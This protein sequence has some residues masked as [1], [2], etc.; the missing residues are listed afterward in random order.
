[1]TVLITSIKQIILIN[2]LN[3]DK[4]LLIRFKKLKENDQIASNF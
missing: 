1:M 3:F 4:K 2:N